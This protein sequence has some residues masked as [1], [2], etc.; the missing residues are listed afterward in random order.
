M[1]DAHLFEGYGPVSG[2]DEMYERM[3]EDARSMVTRESYLE[4][5]DAFQTMGDEEVRQRADALASS[6]LDQ[7][8]TFGVA[9]EERP[10]P[11]DIVPRLIE[12]EQWQQVDHGVRQRVRALEAFLAD[13]YGS[14]E[15]FA[16]GVVPR[17]V[18][19]S[20]PHFHRVVAG[21]EPANGVRIH[22]SGVD[23]IRDGEGDF[24]VLE[25]NVRCPSGVSYVMTNRR[26]LSAALPEVFADHRIR[27]VAQYSRALLAAL[28]KAAPAGVSDPTVVVLTPGVYNSAYFEHTLLARTMGVELVEGRDLVC[29]GGRVLMRTTQGLEPVHVIYRRIDD[30]WLDP[31][32]F[33]PESSLGVPG[34]INAA[35]AGHVTIANAVGNG[36]ADDKLLYTYV[37]D[38]IRYY[39]SEEPILRNVDTWRLGDEDAREEVLDRLD[40]LVLK[41]V[42]GSGGKGIVIGP[43]ATQEELDALRGKIRADPRAWIAQPVVSLSTVPTLV[44]DGIRPRHVDLRPFAVHDGD[45]VWVLPGGLTRV[46]LPEGELIVNSSRGGGSKDTWVLAGPTDEAAE[47]AGVPRAT[48]VAGT[49]HQQSPDLDVSP[50]AD[51]QQQQ[52]QQQQGRSSC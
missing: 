6:Y 32:Q 17:S 20:S 7:G 49:P 5:R 19:T 42:D 47:E 18:V 43:A 37:P 30:D 4:I 22:V 46:A 21:L 24:R 9:G 27:P 41:P 23:L 31:V 51:M 52:Q 35:R 40:E 1:S 48:P 44:E 45:D 28:R 26:A 2:F 3:G 15:L 36:V 10:F 11:L 34:I 14:G 29:R 50:G 38:L 16:D 25:D 33:R 13:V 39:L 8:I 12:A